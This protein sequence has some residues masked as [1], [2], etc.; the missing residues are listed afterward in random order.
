M[1][2]SGPK[3]TPEQRERDLA[4]LSELYLKGMP[5]HELTKVISDQYPEFD[6]SQRTIR[7]D[8]AELRKRWIESQIVNFDEAKAKELELLDMAIAAC[9]QGWENSLRDE[10]YEIT[11]KTE[12]DKLAGGE[13]TLP[14]TLKSIKKIERR[15]MRD[16]S[17]AWI[18]EIRKLSDQRAKILGL[19]EAEKFQID[20]RDRLEK[21]GMDTSKID[22]TLEEALEIVESA[23][24]DTTELPE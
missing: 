1:K 19:Y 15:A 6:L 23:W 2:A 11:E 16:G 14:I 4:I 21:T 18:E 12:G 17:I 22:K 9:W 24:E 7:N 5:E 13:G 3:R 8:K 20:W 10:G